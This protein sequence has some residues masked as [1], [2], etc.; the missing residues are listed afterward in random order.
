M[1]LFMCSMTVVFIHKTLNHL[2][3]QSP[4]FCHTFWFVHASWKF[5][6]VLGD[7]VIL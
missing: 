5:K 6:N 2:R 3:L 7:L 1:H 4:L